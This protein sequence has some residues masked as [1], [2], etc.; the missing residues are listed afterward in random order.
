[1]Y[2]HVWNEKHSCHCRRVQNP[3]CLSCSAE[4]ALFGHCTSTLIIPR[5]QNYQQSISLEGQQNERR[6]H[7]NRCSERPRRVTGRNT[8]T[9]SGGDHFWIFVA[10]SLFEV[11]HSPVRR[12]LG[13]TSAAQDG[14]QNA[15]EDDF[16]RAQDN[17]QSRNGDWENHPPSQSSGAGKRSASTAMKL[18]VL[19]LTLARDGSRCTC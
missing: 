15:L 8:D 14:Y 12:G 16:T 18:W 13:V 11:G 10:T 19:F 7:L 4:T 9:G 3:L 2:L 1:M 5:I 17:A 6:A